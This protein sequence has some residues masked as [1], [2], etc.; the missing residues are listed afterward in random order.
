MNYKI[1]QEANGD[2]EN[3]WLFTYENW[4]LNQADRYFNLIMNE[5]EHLAKHPERQV[6]ILVNSEKGIFVLE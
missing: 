1:S 3:I 6:K 2:L 5:I 4:S